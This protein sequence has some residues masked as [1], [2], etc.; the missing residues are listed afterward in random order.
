MAL[1]TIPFGV[2]AMATFAAVLGGFVVLNYGLGVLGDRLPPGWTDILQGS[3]GLLAISLGA[4]MGVKSPART[5]EPTVKAKGI[6]GGMIF[7]DVNQTARPAADPNKPTL[8]ADRIALKE[9][10]AGK[11]L[12]NGNM[13]TAHAEV[14]VIQQAYDAGVTQGADMTM[15]VNG[16]EVCSYCRSDIVAMARQAGLASIT[17]SETETGTQLFWKP[18]LRGL[19]ENE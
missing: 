3:S 17:I 15:V 14:G 4:F 8:I 16:Q 12:P 10:K 13:A 11:Q 5:P 7:D 9:M 18:G 2:G 1:L 6:V 19:Q